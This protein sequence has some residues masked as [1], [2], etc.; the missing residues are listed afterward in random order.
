MQTTAKKSS[1]FNKKITHVDDMMIHNLIK[2]LVQTR[3]RLS[4]IKI[5]IFNPENSKLNDVRH[6]FVLFFGY[7]TLLCELHNVVHKLLYRLLFVIT[8]NRI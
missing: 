4:D 3:L 8:Q 7:A 2:Y 1:K 6:K 5:I